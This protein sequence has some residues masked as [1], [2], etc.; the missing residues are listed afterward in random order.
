M[1]NRSPSSEEIFH[2]RKHKEKKHKKSDK[3]SRHSSPSLKKKKKKSKHSKSSSLE[4][5]LDVNLEL[6]MSPQLQIRRPS[7]DRSFHEKEFE[8]RKLYHEDTW[9][10]SDRFTPQRSLSPRRNGSPLIPTYCG[11]RSPG[12]EN[13]VLGRRASPRLSHRLI[14]SPHTPP[15]PPKAYENSKLDNRHIPPSPK[16]SP[17]PMNVRRRYLKFSLYYFRN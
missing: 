7:P 14:E 6:S 13:E 9:R 15:L 2:E 16:R 3:K 17:S 5:S 4:K 12:S 8:H 10:G 1:R 11:S